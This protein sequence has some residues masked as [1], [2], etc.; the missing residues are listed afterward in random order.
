MSLLQ[1]V[2]PSTKVAGDIKTGLARAQAHQVAM[3]IVRRLANFPTQ[4]YPTNPA[5]SLAAALAALT[6]KH[7]YRAGL[8]HAQRPQPHPFCSQQYQ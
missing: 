4:A 6:A 1:T 5:L 3:R 7:R 2:A 8:K